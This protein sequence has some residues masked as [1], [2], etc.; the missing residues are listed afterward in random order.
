LFEW[1]GHYPKYYNEDFNDETVTF[2]H[3]IH[4][5][6]DFLE[7]FAENGVAAPL[8]YSVIILLTLGI[9]LFKSKR[10]EKYFYVFLTV[11]SSALFSLVSFP[12]YKF[13]SFF[14]FSVSVG[15]AL[16]GVK[17]DQNKN[18]LLKFSHLKIFL[19]VCL[20]AAFVISFIKLRSEMNFVNALQFLNAKMYLQMNERLNSVSSILYPYDPSKQPVDYYRGIA[21]SY[22]NNKS[23]TLRDNLHALELAPFSPVIMNNVASSYHT[24]G[25][26]QEA[27]SQFEK[28]KDIFPDYTDPQIKLLYIYTGVKQLEKG[29]ALLNELLTKFP[30]DPNLRQIQ[31]QYYTP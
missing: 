3:S 22:L 16:L 19:L 23:Q 30:D 24:T 18:L 27:I 31:M 29:K 10:D 1:S 8:L 6:N 25:N 13:S 11:L 9:L 15:I 21:S 20:I 4:A 28:M 12:A 5:H 2:V 14:L 7:L 17:E 26:T